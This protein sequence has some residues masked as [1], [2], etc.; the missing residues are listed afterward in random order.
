M[1]QETIAGK[2]RRHLGK[3]FFV[4]HGHVRMPMQW[5]RS[6]KKSRQ[7]FASLLHEHYREESPMSQATAIPATL[8]ALVAAVLAGYGVLVRSVR[9]GSGFYRVWL[10]LAAMAAAAAVTVGAGAWRSMPVA[11]RVG[12]PL[13]ALAFVIWA[14]TLSAS[15]MR[16]TNTLVPDDLDVL[17]V[18]GAQVR[19]DGSP[20]SALRMRL[21]TA[22][23]YLLAHPRCR[24]IVSGGQGANEPQSEAECMASCLA[25]G[26]VNPERILLE[27]QSRNT[28]QNL[29]F[30][31]ELLL[32]ERPQ[33]VGIV[34]N[35]FH[36]KRSLAIARR[37]GIPN[38]KGIA[39]P[40]TRLYLPNN[41]LRECF[42]IALD[43][44]RSR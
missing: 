2:S 40:S 18:L 22:R 29:R 17:V 39:A 23:D 42:C 12:I 35:D 14:I 26:G 43:F 41:L 15:V 44:L 10:A 5:Q 16:Q 30:S 7:D 13:A 25:F 27:D 19:P 33:G 9:S 1:S 28:I 4:V 36:L 37:E 20:C 24:C 21:D 34:T 11:L 38:P 8:L 3:L 32:E 31:R 6:R